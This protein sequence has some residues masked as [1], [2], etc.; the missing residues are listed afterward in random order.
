MLIRYINIKRKKMNKKK[1][2]P[3]VLL[4]DIETAPILARVWGIW[5]QT[6]GLNQIVTD[7]HLLSW[8]AKWLDDKKI[9]YQD[10]RNAK[11]ITNDKKLLERLWHLLDEAD[12]VITQN[13]KSFDQKKVNARFILN[14]MSPPSTYKHIDTKRLATKHFGF[15]S[16]KLEFLTD[17][18]CTKNKKLTKRKFSGF[19]LWTACLAG[20]KAAWAE[21]QR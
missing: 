5:D 3:R 11:D 9:M 16:N 4:F 21:M 20:N 10:Q 13:G 7:W 15:T 8:S 1:N 19:S 18:L 2:S 12:I 17:K 14:G 6:V